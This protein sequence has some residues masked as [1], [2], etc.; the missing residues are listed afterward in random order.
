MKESC[1]F[2][3]G[4]LLAILLYWFAAQQQTSTSRRQKFDLF[5]PKFSSEF[6]KLILTFQEQQE[7][8]KKWLKQKQSRKHVFGV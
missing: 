6:N 7:I 2:E 3:T 8:A 1:L 4:F 5:D